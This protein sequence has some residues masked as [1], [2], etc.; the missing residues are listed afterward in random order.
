MSPRRGTSAISFRRFQ[1]A[2]LSLVATFMPNTSHRVTSA[3]PAEFKYQP[4]KPG[5]KAFV[6]DERN[7]AASAVAL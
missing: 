4:A 7:L 6:V 1:A 5:V 3:K 2:Q